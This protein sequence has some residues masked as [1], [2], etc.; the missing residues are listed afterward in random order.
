M[1]EAPINPTVAP[2]GMVVNVCVL[3]TKNISNGRV[4]ARWVAPQ[5]IAVPPFSGTIAAQ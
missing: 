5:V 3:S 4:P 2:A 1:D